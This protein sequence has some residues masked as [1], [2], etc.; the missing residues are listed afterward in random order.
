[1]PTSTEWSWSFIRASRRI[2][3]VLFGLLTIR[4]PSPVL[5]EYEYTYDED[6]CD[7]TGEAPT[8][9]CPGNLNVATFA[10]NCFG[11][12]MYDLPVASDDCQSADEMTVQFKSGIRTNA[13]A[14]PT[15]EPVSTVYTVL[16]AVFQQG[17]C[18]F[19]VHVVDTERPKIAC[20]SDVAKDAANGE[21]KAGVEYSDPVASDN[22]ANPITTRTSGGASGA[23]FNVG[24]HTVAYEIV[25]VSK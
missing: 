3:L 17:T 13:G 23:H 19:D 16:D 6:E 10:G 9:Q 11:I 8:L 2:M 4:V 14:P 15:K 20:P 24:V 21:C 18:S 22:C 7:T 12:V 1:V 5:S 25:A